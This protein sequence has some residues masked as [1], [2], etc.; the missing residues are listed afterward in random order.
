MTI[1]DSGQKTLLN[2]AREA[3]GR[4]VVH[5]DAPELLAD[6]YP[7]P[8]R[9][10]ACTFVTLHIGEALRGCI[11]S[12]RAHRPLVADVARHAYAA[13]FSDA[14]FNPV[15]HTELDGLHIHVSILSELQPVTFDSE[16]SLLASLRP[17]TDG[18]LIEVGGQ[19]ATFLPTVWSS[20]PDGRNFLA[21]LK[22]KAGMDAGTTAYSAWRYTT[23]DFEESHD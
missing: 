7:A 17:G 8:L 1:D 13:A 2:V 18:L 21:A 23:Q 16:S 12:L 15:E 9:V 5:A 20:F 3:I 11:G 4:G 19:R 14:R 10:I 22:T 6:Q